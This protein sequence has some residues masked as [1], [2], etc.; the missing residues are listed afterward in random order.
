MTKNLKDEI[1]VLLKEDN[2]QK[3]H[4]QIMNVLKNNGTTMKIT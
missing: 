3:L 1:L 4:I 2:E